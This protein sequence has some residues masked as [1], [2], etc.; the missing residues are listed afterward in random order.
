MSTPPSSISLH[1][2]EPEITEVSGDNQQQTRQQIRQPPVERPP[3]RSSKTSH[4]DRREFDDLKPRSASTE[5]PI[6]GSSSIRRQ[7][8][9]PVIAAPETT[10]A[11]EAAPNVVVVHRTVPRDL[12]ELQER[13]NEHKYMTFDLNELAGVLN[14]I[15]PHLLHRGGHGTLPGNRELVDAI[16]PDQMRRGYAALNMTPDHVRK[17]ESAAYWAG[18]FIPSSSS[19]FNMVS[20]LVIPFATQNVQNPWVTA[21]LSLGVVGLQPFITAPLQSLII[22]TIDYYR[23]LGQPE[24]KLDKASVNSA[25]TQSAIKQE[26]ETRIAAAK[27]SEQAVAEIFKR[28]GLVDRDDLVDPATLSA[29]LAA[30]S[31]SAADKKELIDA[32]KAH[33]DALMALCAAATQMNAL[34]GSHARQI[35]STLMQI[36]PRT[37]R[38]G[39]GIVA[40]FVKERGAQAPQSMLDNLVSNKLSLMHVTAVS[41]SIAM[42]AIVFQHMA[43]ARDEVNGLRHEHKLNLLYADVFKEGRRDVALRQGAITPDDLSEEKLRGLRVPAEATVVLRVADRLEADLDKLE[44]ELERQRS[45]PASPRTLEEGAA[46]GDPELIDKIR[47]Y[48]RDVNNLRDLTVTGDIHEDTHALLNSA[49]SGSLSF[50]LGEAYAKLTKPLELTSQIS[51]RLGQ[52]FTLGVAGSASATAGGRLATA[53]LGGSSHVSLAAQFYLSLASA[54]VGVFSAATQGLVT[55]VKNQRRDAD[56]EEAMGFWTQMVKGASAPFLWGNNLWKS[57]RGRQEA[58]TAFAEFQEQARR[59]G[60]SFTLL[61]E[62]ATAGELEPP[63]RGEGPSTAAHQPVP[64]PVES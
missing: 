52:T 36:A 30:H 10:D 27:A 58:G 32:S 25:T 46:E 4:A 16:T 50:A 37:L 64:P 29:R 11:V 38:S 48:R 61:D 63:D 59:V 54:A 42:A 33:L 41:S 8:S 44:G 2:I 24:L 60:E 9:L 39:S 23:R 56:P 17:M 47:A 55:N 5:L 51:Q 26:I 53:A 21:S 3:S 19:V 7:A 15:R 45:A 34:D 13:L 62:A 22:G 40:P 1:T 6:A 43:A 31:L 18:M 12:A 20:Y 28:H 49:L 57:W 35:E 14:E